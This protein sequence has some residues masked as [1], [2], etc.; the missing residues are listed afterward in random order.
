MKLKH[1]FAVRQIAGEYV[2]IPMGKSALEFSG[3]VT[4]NS[5]GAFL[6][7]QLATEK[8]KAQLLEAVCGEFEVEE[9]EALADL[10]QFLQMLRRSG[11]LAE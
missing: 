3:M 1:A 9:R 5:V 2:L 11:L 6:C 7:E 8:T 10:E 4:T